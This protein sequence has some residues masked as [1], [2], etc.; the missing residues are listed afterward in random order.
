[1][2]ELGCGYGSEVAKCWHVKLCRQAAVQFQTYDAFSR[3][4]MSIG[5]QQL[6]LA[7]TYY[8]LGYLLVE[9]GTKGPAVSAVIGFTVIAEMILS[10]DMTL[11]TLQLRI[12]QILLAVGPIC[13]TLGA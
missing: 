11:T 4:C 9:V 13:A 10:F 7:M 6:M 5:V 8:L 3:I 2:P 12:A 1:M